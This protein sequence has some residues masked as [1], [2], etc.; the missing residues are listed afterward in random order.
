MLEVHHRGRRWG[1]VRVGRGGDQKKNGEQGDQKERCPS[2][3]CGDRMGEKAHVSNFITD[4][5]F[6]GVWHKFLVHNHIPLSTLIWSNLFVIQL[7]HVI[8]LNSS[9]DTVCWEQRCDSGQTGRQVR[10]GSRVFIVR[11]RGWM[12]VVNRTVLNP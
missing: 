3:L 2:I 6:K 5:S 9:I 8:W 1:A 4:H 11:G 12:V 7:T 10:Q